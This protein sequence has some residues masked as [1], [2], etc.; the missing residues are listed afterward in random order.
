MPARHA[1]GL[2]PVERG[3][4]DLR[5]AQRLGQGQRDLDLDVVALAREDRRLEHVGDDEQ[6]AGRSAVAARLALAGE[7]D[8]AALAHAR[9]N[10][11]AVALDGPLAALAVA[12][13]AGV[14]DDRPGAAALRAGLGDRE[15]AL[16]LDLDAAPAAARADDRRRARLG[17]G[18]GAGRA[19]LVGGDGDRHLRA[20]DRLVEADR[21]LGLEVAAALGAWLASRRPPAAAAAAPAAGGLAEE[22]GEDVAEAARVEARLA[23]AAAP[24]VRERVAQLAVVLLALVGIAE[25]VVGLGDL[26]EALLGLRVAR[27]LV[28]VVLAR[29][30]AVG[31]LDVVGRRLALDAEHLVVILGGGHLDV[32]YPATIT[33]AGRSTA[34]LS[35]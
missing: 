13:R 15:Q 26:L 30:L 6:V 32:S 16:A 19:A 2:A 29:E 31:L 22:V 21:D 28:G 33:R 9:G 3:D 35:L 5:A 25:H 10:V 1:Q 14:L 17:A 18:A 4:L 24:D 8:L 23:A 27:V 20:G 12:G 7:A 11:D 34:S